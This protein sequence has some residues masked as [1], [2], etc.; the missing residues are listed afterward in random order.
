VLSTLHMAVGINFF[1]LESVKPSIVYEPFFSNTQQLAV[2]L[3]EKCVKFSQGGGAELDAMLLPLII[4]QLLI[5]WPIYT[6]D[7]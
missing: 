4:K 5:P 6:T 2:K 7:G 3:Y 1:F